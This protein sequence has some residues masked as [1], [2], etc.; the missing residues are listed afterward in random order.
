MV[1]EVLV[2]RGEREDTK[3][4]LDRVSMDF[5]RTAR[6]AGCPH[7]RWP[8]VLQRIGLGKVGSKLFHSVCE[9]LMMLSTRP[10]KVSCLN[11]MGST[12]E[13]GVSAF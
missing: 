13:D 8:P 10:A 2:G 1:E 7:S 4:L 3:H 12:G 6:Q 5:I 9:R 11:T